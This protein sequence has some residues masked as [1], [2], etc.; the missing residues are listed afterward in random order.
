MHVKSG[1]HKSPENTPSIDFGVLS[2]SLRAV[3]MGVFQARYWRY[4]ARSCHK[5]AVLEKIKTVYFDG[6][7][8]VCSNLHQ[9]PSEP[10]QLLS[11]HF[12]EPTTELV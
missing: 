5:H 9:T 3:D 2:G 12:F 1:M 11:K 4:G 6:N 7:G 8:S 10:D